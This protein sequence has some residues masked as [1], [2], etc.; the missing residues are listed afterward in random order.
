[1]FKRIIQFLKRL[2]R[3]K[4]PD[5]RL[6]P[7]ERYILTSGKGPPKTQPYQ[8]EGRE[9]DRRFMAQMGFTTRKKMKRYMKKEIPKARKRVYE[10]RGY[11]HRGRPTK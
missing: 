5:P 1:M 11:D 9:A 6:P 2:F 10:E 4:K 8:S 7:S 3:R